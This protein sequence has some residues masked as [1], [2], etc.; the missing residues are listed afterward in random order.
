M[1][2]RH[3]LLLGL[4]L[5]SSLVVMVGRAIRGACG[6][7]EAQPACCAAICFA[8]SLCPLSLMHTRSATPA[9]PLRLQADDDAGSDS[10][11]AEP[12]T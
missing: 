2:P 3:W 9:R 6:P 12:P 1:A 11:D 10:A 4:L 7:L 8:P 5:S